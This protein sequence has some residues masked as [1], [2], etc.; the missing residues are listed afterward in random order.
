MTPASEPVTPSRF[1]FPCAL[2][3][4]ELQRADTVKAEADRDDALSFL[5]HDAE[6]QAGIRGI[7][8]AGY[9][10]VA[11]YVDHY[12]T[13]RAKNDAAS[14]RARR[15]PTSDEPTKT[16]RLAWSALTAA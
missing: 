16:K 7:A 3:A 11:E 4:R 13:V 10:A 9:Q 15:L 12:A 2:Q 8:W 1:R 6:T 5:F 14:A